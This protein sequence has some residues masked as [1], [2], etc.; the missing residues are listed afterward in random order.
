MMCV[1][2]GPVLC[3]GRLDPHG[4]GQLNCLG[5]M[6]RARG[7]IGDPHTHSSFNERAKY[8]LTPNFLISKRSPCRTSQ[9][10][11]MF[12]SS[13]VL[14]LTFTSPA[15]QRSMKSFCV[16]VWCCRALY[17]PY[18]TSQLILDRCSATSQIDLSMYSLERSPRQLHQTPSVLVCPRTQWQMRVG[19]DTYSI[20]SRMAPCSLSDVGLHSPLR[21]RQCICCTSNGSQ[22]GSHRAR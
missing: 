5:R 8:P 11:R 22:S 17:L 6:G 15:V 13:G 14:R 4:I 12:T 21:F 2:I 3:L 1:M 9:I 16:R 18:R 19:C 7:F 10:M 20:S